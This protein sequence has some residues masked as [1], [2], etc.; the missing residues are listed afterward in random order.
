MVQTFSSN[1]KIFSVDLMFAYLNIFDHEISTIKISDF[2]HTLDYKGWG[3]PSENVFYSPRDVLKNP[4][5]KM[6]KDEIKRIEE[7][8]LSYP[9]IIY[10]NNIVDGVH[11]LTKSYIKNKKTIKAYVFDKDLMKNFLIDN[12]GDWTKVDNMKM[13][14]FIKLFYERF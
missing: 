8:D 4:T 12:K 9:I 2:I 6:Y 1:K 14:E 13:Y 5:K 10:N 3:D 11:R 7:A